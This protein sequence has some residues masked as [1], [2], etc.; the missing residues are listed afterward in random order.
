MKLIYSHLFLKASSSLS[1]PMMYQFDTQYETECQ[2]SSS[3]KEDTVSAIWGS[4][5]AK[6][7]WISQVNQLTWIRPCWCNIR[8]IMCKSRLDK[9]N[10]KFMFLFIY[11]KNATDEPLYQ[12]QIYLNVCDKVSTKN[13]S[14]N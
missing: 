6:V 10:K 12:P 14:V 2:C 8:P 3:W 9:Y 11:N 4:S 1:N 5:C 7:G 13:T